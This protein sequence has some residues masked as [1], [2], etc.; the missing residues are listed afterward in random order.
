MKKEIIITILYGCA[1]I[2]FFAYLITKKSYFQFS[3]GLL[4]IVASIMLIINNKSK[5]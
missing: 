1:V 3:G 4:L 2:A 5:K